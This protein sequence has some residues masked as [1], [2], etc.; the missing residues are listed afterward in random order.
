[1]GIKK[2]FTFFKT[3]FKNCNIFIICFYYSNKLNNFIQL[4]LLI[5]IVRLQFANFGM[6]RIVKMIL[7]KTPTLMTYKNIN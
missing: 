6:K 1:M 4:K 2:D 3:L 5:L 7:L